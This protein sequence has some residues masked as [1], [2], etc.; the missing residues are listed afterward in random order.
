MPGAVAAPAPRRGGARRSPSEVLAD[1]L[2]GNERFVQGRPR[3]GHDVTA[4]A[5]V[6]GSQEPGAVVVGCMDSRVPLEAIFD[7][8]F[9]AICVARSAGHVLDQAVL[10][11][12]EFAV[13]QLRVPL[14]VVL[15]HERC[16]AVA[17]TIDALRA[18]QRPGGALNYLIDE[19]APAVAEVGLDSPDVHARALRVHIRSTVRRLRA[20]K[21]VIE[22]PTGDI[23]VVGAVYNL[24][25]GR[26]DVLDDAPSDGH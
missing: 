16:G 3:Y 1:L 23:A 18:G 25:T 5:A 12:I 10:G 22:R 24:D 4:A 7:Q 14:V 20:E 9:G 15:G 2:A 19:I 11:S 26:V 21:R 13:W 8:T 17:A 6:A